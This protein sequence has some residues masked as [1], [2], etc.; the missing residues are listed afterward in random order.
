MSKPEDVRLLEREAIEL[1]R[2]AVELD[3]RGVRSLAIMKYRNAIEALAKLIN[4]DPDSPISRAY[5][6]KIREYRDRIQF[7][8]GMVAEDAKDG[9]RAG[10][11]DRRSV[12]HRKGATAGEIIR[13][14]ELE[15]FLVRSYK[16]SIGWDDVVDLEHVKKALKQAIVYP[17]LRPDLFPLGWP[18]GIL[19][20]GPPGCGKT[21]VAAA[22]SGEINGYFYP[23]DAAT[24]MSKWLG[25]TEKNIARLFNFLRGK[26]RSGKP[27]ILFLDEAESLLGHRR[28][29]VGGEVRA[30]S[31]LLKEI[32]G[33]TE[34]SDGRLPLYIIA[35]TNKPWNLDWGFIRRFQKRIYIPIPNYH[36]RVRLFKFFLRN[37]AKEQID[38][39]RLAKA[40]EG[41]TSSDIKDVCQTAIIEVVTEL[42][43]SGKARDLSS[44][45]RPLT[46]DD[47]L[48]AVKRAR[49]S[50][51]PEMARVY[52]SW[53]ERFKSV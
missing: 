50:V 44:R 30:R 5:L 41:Y 29:E 28:E 34:K 4:V 19:L 7:L 45:P 20:Y 8:R 32:D 18:R 38:Y 25:E 47:L 53:A 35:A 3:R 51:A 14:Q 22:V 46:T 36:V 43:E 52:E 15:P 48:L 39:E 2:E 24:L 12:E 49:P 6:R 23:V 16:S 21:T 9:L 10:L 1:A 40:T 31:Q 13:G 26:A 17:T 11:G 37:V 42:F 33:L 27:V